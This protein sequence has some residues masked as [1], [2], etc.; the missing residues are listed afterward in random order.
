MHWKLKCSKVKNTFSSNWWNF[1][2]SYAIQKWN[3]SWYH[4][5][6]PTIKIFIFQK[7]EQV[8]SCCWLRL[9]ENICFFFVKFWKMHRKLKFSKVKSTFSSNWWNF[10]KSYVMRKW[11]ESWYNSPMRNAKIF[12]FQNFWQDHSWCWHHINKIC[13]F[14]LMK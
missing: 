5:Q 3:Y 12:I 14:I 1:S 2:K 10:S 7:F 13:D 11:N 9:N 6:M 8:W 4:S